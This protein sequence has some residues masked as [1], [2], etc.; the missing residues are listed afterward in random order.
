MNEGV[1][2][3]I[4]GRAVHLRR[5][6]IGAV[7]ESDLEVRPLSVGPLQPGSVATRTLFGSLDPVLRLR[8]SAGRDDAFD[9]GAVVRSRSVAIVEHSAADGFSPGDLVLGWSG[10]QTRAVERADLL[11]PILPSNVPASAYLGALGRP[12]ITAWLGMVHVG[13]VGPGDTVTVSSAAGAVGSTAGQLARIHGARVVG[14]AGGPEKC[15]WLTRECGFDAA[16]DYKDPHFE[17]RL[18]EA[19]PD[20]VTLHFESVGGAVLD[21]VLA[22]MSPHGRISLCGLL[23]SYQSTSA[24]AYKNFGLILYRALRIQGFRIDDYR[25]LHDEATEHLRAWA[26]AGRLRSEETT[27]HGIDALPQAFVDMLAGRGRGKHLVQMDHKPEKAGD[28]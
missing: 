15:A 9:V 4:A 14:I 24:F 23:Q 1:L 13:R 7:S 18:V 27:C 3:P 12:G 17:Q 8:M 5:Q 20:G 28:T 2:R 10:W 21:A 26:E 22:R 25:D 6:P 19:T 16:V 11:I